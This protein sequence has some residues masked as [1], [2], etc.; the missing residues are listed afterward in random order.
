MMLPSS[1][2]DTLLMIDKWCEEGTAVGLERIK[3]VEK[4][5]AWTAAAE[6]QAG[7]S[8]AAGE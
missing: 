1:G 2:G 4:C 7:T 3:G 5:S 6:L 8:V